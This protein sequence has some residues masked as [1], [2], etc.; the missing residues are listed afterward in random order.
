MATSAMDMANQAAGQE[1]GD[2][3]TEP[4]ADCNSNPSNIGYAIPPGLRYNVG[5]SGGN[6][7]TAKGLASPITIDAVLPSRVVRV[8]LT[9][10]PYHEVLAANDPDTGVITVRIG[11]QSHPLARWRRVGGKMIERQFGKGE[12]ERLSPILNDV[13]GRIEQAFAA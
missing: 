3:L 8:E 4:Q 7:S 11:C 6:I 1:T 10:A 5:G 12:V 13:L 2:T 9:N